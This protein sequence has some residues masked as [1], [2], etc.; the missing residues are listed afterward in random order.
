MAHIGKIYPQ[1][2]PGR[3][4]NPFH[5]DSQGYPTEFQYQTDGWYG[6]IGIY[7]DP[8]GRG[9]FPSG[10]PQP[11]LTQVYTRTLSGI[12]GPP[13]VCRWTFQFL[14]P[15]Q[16][17]VC[18]FEGYYGSVLQW[19]SGQANCGANN[20]DGTTTWIVSDEY[21]PESNLIYVFPTAVAYPGNFM[22]IRAR[23]WRDG[24]PKPPASA[25]F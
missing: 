18:R 15:G 4:L 25:P 11:D 6:T 16:L 1:W 23:L 13:F 19:T 12:L 21:P 5:P 24:A 9:V 20:Y 8:G 3:V 2:N 10:L 17:S 14:L 7:A 22:T